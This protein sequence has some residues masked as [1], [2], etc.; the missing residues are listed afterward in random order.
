MSKMKLLAHM[1]MAMAAAESPNLYSTPE[2]K[3]TAEKAEDEHKR[4]VSKGLTKFSYKEGHI[5]AINRKV[6]DKKA[7]KKWG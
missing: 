7:K 4:N 5:W 2:R 1:F 6:A 3:T